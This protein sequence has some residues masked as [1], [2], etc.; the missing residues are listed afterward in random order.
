MKR[1]LIVEDEPNLADGLEMN[2]SAEGYEAI[3][4]R[5]ANEA[6]ELFERIEFDLA[7]LDI[8]LPGMDGVTL[9][10]ELRKRSHLPIIFLSARDSDSDKITGLDVGAD[11][12]I[13]KPFNLDELLRRINALFRRVSWETVAH[14]SSGEIV[15]GDCS[16]DLKTLDARGP[17]GETRLSH[18]E[19][20]VLKYLYERRGEIV[21]RDMLLD[22]VWGYTAFPSTRTVDNFILRLRKV[23]EIDPAN[24]KVITSIRGVGYKLQI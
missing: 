10:K 17:G 13:T 9:C 7:L 18:K 1:I 21:S 19:A 20:M 12:Y 15:F 8:M 5:D 23:F 3:V 2:L 22:G 4:A 11:D 24:P 16:L 6:L 14:K